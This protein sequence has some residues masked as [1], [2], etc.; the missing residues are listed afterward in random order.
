MKSLMPIVACGAAF[1]FPL[2]GLAADNQQMRDRMKSD[3]DII[4]N[5]FEVSYAPKEWKK[6]FANWDLDSEIQ[7]A[8]D[9][10][11]NAD[12]ITVKAYQKIIKEFFNSTKDYHVGVWF[13]STER[14]TLPFA[15]KGAEG[16]YFI[17]S[18]DSLRLAPF[19]F[20]I[21]IGDELVT[22]GGQPIGEVI[23][24]LM[25]SEFQS[26]NEATDRAFA[27]YALTRRLGSVAHRIPKG[28]ITIGIK[29]LGSEKV[30][31]YQ[32]IW[33]YSPEKISNG[34]SGK[35]QE[36]EYS[37]IKLDSKHLYRT[38]FNKK[39]LAPASSLFDS[40]IDENNPSNPAARSFIGN[41]ESF[42]PPLGKIW[43]ENPE[44][45]LFKAYLYENED[46]KLIGYVRIP[47]FVGFD[48]DVSEFASLLT[49]FNERSDALVIDQVDNPGGF[50]FYV[51]ALASM[52]SDK[53]LC[54]PKHRMTVTTADVDFAIK[55]IPVFE[56]IQTDAEAQ[57]FLGPTFFGMPVTHQMALFF[58][59][60]LRFI[61]S[62][63]N[64][65]RVLTDPYFLYSIDHINPHTSVR[66]TKPILLLIN[67]LDLSGGDF[68][69]A[70]LQDNQCATTFG[71]RT[72]GAGGY[73]LG[74]AFPNLF[75]IAYFHYTGS[76]AERVNKN[77]IENL[78]VTPDIPYELTAEDYQNNY[79]G[80]MDAVNQAVKK[81]LSESLGNAHSTQRDTDAETQRKN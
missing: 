72:A 6:S 22:F 52:L 70:I 17:S 75:G 63:W 16:R 27:E 77:P 71:T 4:K 34:F 23:N 24:E 3:L 2:L 45:K 43:W 58:L 38:F 5:A 46:H 65:G 74:N 8:K 60:F 50:V 26:A 48:E 57:A 68:F 18:I 29:S 9:K 41:K 55:A 44:D 11:Q 79:E 35:I 1:L 40:E 39:M 13:Y 61:V 20:P 51:Y 14:A 67:S 62:E 15:V 42:I 28:P 21:N 19:V 36:N 64:Q 31:I 81:I 80:Y 73:V 37:G 12:K 69:P 59:D 25:S 66:Y 47:H 33:D 30:S 56:T 76:I 78:G 49:F 10:I 54:T 32:L 53:P 7:K